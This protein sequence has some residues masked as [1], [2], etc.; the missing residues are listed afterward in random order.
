MNLIQLLKNARAGLNW[1]VELRHAIVIL[2]PP[3][4]LLMHFYLRSLSVTTTPAIL[5]IHSMQYKLSLKPW[6][7]WV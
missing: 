6:I 2:T 3:S 4:C 1:L 5:K 7:N